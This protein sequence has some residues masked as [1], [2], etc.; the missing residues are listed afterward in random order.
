MFVVHLSLLHLHL[1]R[2]RVLHRWRVAE[3]LRLKLLTDRRIDLRV[4]NLIIRTNFRVVSNLRLRHQMHHLRLALFQKRR[5]HADVRVAA[6]FIQVLVLLQ[7]LLVN[8][9]V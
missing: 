9:L 5:R 6:H 8:D 1:T 2:L 7:L 4:H 3:L